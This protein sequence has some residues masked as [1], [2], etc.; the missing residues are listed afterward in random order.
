MNLDMKLK[1]MTK[2]MKLLLDSNPS[3]NN[4]LHTKEI[5]ENIKIIN[6]EKSNYAKNH[7]VFDYSMYIF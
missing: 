7:V 6:L 5:L 1:E 4:I 2:E 3:E